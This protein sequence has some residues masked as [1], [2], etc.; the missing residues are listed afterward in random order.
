MWSAGAGVNTSSKG[1]FPNTGNGY[2]FSWVAFGASIHYAYTVLVGARQDI[3]AD[4]SAPASSNP[5][6]PPM[7]PPPAVGTGP[8]Y[9]PIE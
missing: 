6:E 3:Y 4:A 5:G 7:I 2:F 1:P 9:Q 8:G